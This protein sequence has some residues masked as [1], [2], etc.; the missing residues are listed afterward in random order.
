MKKISRLSCCLPALYALAA[1]APVLKAEPTLPGQKTEAAQPALKPKNTRPD[2]LF[3]LVDDL[4]WDAFSFMGHPFVKTP[5]ID[6]LR[7]RGALL[8]NSF[9]TTSLCGPSRATFLTGTYDSRNGVVDNQGAEYV[10][11]VTPPFTMELQKAGYRVAFIGKWHMADS[12]EPRPGFDYWLSFRGQG[13]YNNPLFNINGKHV[14]EYGYT[15]DLLTDYA[16]DFIKKQ[17]LDQPYFL[18]LS[19]KAVHEPFTP[20]PRDKDIW[21]GPSLA[22]KKPVSYDDTF[23]GKAVW[24][25]R[26]HVFD[27]RW[28]RRDRDWADIQVPASIPKEPFK[29]G[30]WYAE[31]LRCVA[32]VDEDL[33]KIID[34]LKKRGTLDRTLIVVAG[35]NGYFHGE[36][37]RWDKRVFYDE[38][39]RIPMIFFYPPE[40]APGTTVKQLVANVDFAP[41]IL[42][43]AGLKKT[44]VMQGESM[45]PLLDGR[46]V[47]WRKA[48]FYEYWV[49]LVHSIPTTVAVRTERYK[50]VRFPEIDDL[51]ELYDLKKDPHEM[52]NVVAHREYAA[53]RDRMEKLLKEQMKET[54]WKAH[55]FPLNIPAIRGPKGTWLDLQIEGDKVVNLAGKKTLP[56]NSLEV[57]DGAMQFKGHDVL[58]LPPSE[59]LNLAQGPITID[60][61]IRPVSDG[62]ILSQSTRDAGLKLFI[63]DGIPGLDV[64]RKTWVGVHSTVDGQRNILGGWVHLRGIIGL[65]EISLWVDEKKVASM[66]LPLSYDS[67]HLAPLVIGASAKPEVYDKTPENGF[68]GELKRLSISRE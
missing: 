46:D 55:P 30:K 33:G 53:V 32:A 66:P 15:T 57:A 45:R 8:A 35:D 11:Q 52:V 10:P 39:M 21:G 9:C 5:N 24:Q 56:A 60:C 17:P 16:I 48:V 44:E 42:D 63:Q 27:D 37:R 51:D 18:E 6:K 62:V 59:E 22:V 43:Y 31:Q 67:K 38:A 34:L 58:T 23:A 19:H 28:E 20:P 36:H 25:R 14:Q 61:W 1:S 41:T 49:D 4:R 26:E 65:K 54:G 64:Y 50:F 2:V 7:A 13:V 47:P 3:V 29:R 40:I 68:G 12:D